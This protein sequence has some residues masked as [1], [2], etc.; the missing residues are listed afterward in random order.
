MPFR[1]ING[2]YHVQGYDPDGDSIRFRAHTPSNWTTLSGPPVR[3]NA[4]G[5]A[6]LRLEGIDALELHYEE[7]HQPLTFAS[8]ARDALLSELG[9]ALV[10]GDATN[11]AAIADDGVE[12]YI[13]ART[14]EQ[15]RRP[16]AFAFAGPPAA[17][18]G[19]SA[20]LDVSLL[21]QSANYKLVDAGLVFPTYYTGLFHDLRS[22]LTAA[23]TRARGSGLGLWP[24]D[25]TNSGVEGVDL[26]SITEREIVLPK[27]FRRLV[28]Y[29]G[30][31]GGIA[32]FK[33]FL[34]AEADAVL[35]LSRGQFTHLDTVVTVTDSTVALDVPPED[36][37]FQE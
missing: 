14:T 5:H 34:A 13:L 28:T 8:A 32:G 24:A 26:V 23:V 33:Q 27:L 15:N 17:A 37:V 10:A 25:K 1:V 36:L 9:I 22:E 20:F 11:S 29:L 18:D 16:V 4:Y 35:I 12:G 30:T 2:T 6:Q 21:R 19:H 7:S 31:G 3:L